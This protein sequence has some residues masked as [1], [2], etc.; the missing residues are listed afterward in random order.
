MA[1]IDVCYVSQTDRGQRPLLQEAERVAIMASA[2]IGRVGIYVRLLLEIWLSWGFP[3][4]W[5][6]VREVN[7]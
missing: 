6:A 3:F 5:F 4:V 1:A 7:Y 2:G